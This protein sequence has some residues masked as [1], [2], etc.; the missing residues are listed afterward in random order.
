MVQPYLYWKVEFD[1]LITVPAIVVLLLCELGPKVLR[2]YDMAHQA[3]A[4]K[5]VTTIQSF[6]LNCT[7][8]SH[9]PISPAVNFGIG[10]HFHYIVPFYQPAACFACGQLV[11]R[12][13]CGFHVY[14]YIYIYLCIRT[15]HVRKNYVTY[16][17]AMRPYFSRL[18]Q[19][20]RLLCV[21]AMSSLLQLCDFKMDTEKQRQHR[22]DDVRLT[23]SGNARGEQLNTCGACRVA[24]QQSLAWLSGSERRRP[25][26]F[27]DMKYQTC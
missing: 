15:Y 10:T 13:L 7:S 19:F 17:V 14:I 4:L 3:W 11:L 23:E 1:L 5:D 22:R 27:L 6:L 12:L 26:W 21:A 24:N 8:I 20:R 9:R 18:R 25:G 2:I 16:I